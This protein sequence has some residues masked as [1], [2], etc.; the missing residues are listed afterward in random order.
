MFDVCT[1]ETGYEGKGRIWM[2]WWRQEEAENQPRVTV[3]DI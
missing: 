2:P 3:E 1:I